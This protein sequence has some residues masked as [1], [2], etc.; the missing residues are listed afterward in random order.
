MA[1]KQFSKHR[2]RVANAI[3][4]LRW[5]MTAYKWRVVADTLISMTLA[6]GG[7]YALQLGDT[8]PAAVAFGSAGAINVK[9]ARMAR[10]FASYERPPPKYEDAWSEAEE[11]EFEMQR[12]DK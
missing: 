11:E 9:F 8:I 2:R 6:M 5:Y 12:K 7:I 1:T 4:G 10:Y 3:V